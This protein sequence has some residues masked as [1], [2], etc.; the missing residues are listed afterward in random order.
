[1]IDPEKLRKVQER[2]QKIQEL[3]AEFEKARDIAMHWRNYPGLTQEEAIRNARVAYHKLQ[4]F[5]R[6]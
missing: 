6:R 1:M 5:I 2:K 3:T 4:K